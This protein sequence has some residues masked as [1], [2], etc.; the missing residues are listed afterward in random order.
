MSASSPPPLYGGLY[1]ER[2]GIAPPPNPEHRWPCGGSLQPVVRF[3]S[4]EILAMPGKGKQSTW[5]W[6][7]NFQLKK[8]LTL[9][10]IGIAGLMMKVLTF[11]P[12]LSQLERVLL[13]D[14]QRPTVRHHHSHGQGGPAGREVQRQRST[15]PTA[16]DE[17][18]CWILHHGSRLEAIVIA[19]SSAFCRKKIVTSSVPPWTPWIMAIMSTIPRDRWRPP[20]WQSQIL[21]LLGAQWPSLCPRLRWSCSSSVPQG[22]WE[23]G[24]G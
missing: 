2:C 20:W 24:Q 3:L 21:V 12:V 10:R 15:P 7:S 22:H 8:L 4:F 16:M 14:E 11:L 13:T 19:S 23:E 18:H 17:L 5:L 1:P 9:G 6:T